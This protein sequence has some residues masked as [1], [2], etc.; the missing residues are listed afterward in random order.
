V[1]LCNRYASLR[2]WEE[3]FVSIYGSEDYSTL[4]TEAAGSSKMLGISSAAEGIIFEIKGINFLKVLS[5]Y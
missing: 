5:L 3:Y 4:Q 2:I 1:T